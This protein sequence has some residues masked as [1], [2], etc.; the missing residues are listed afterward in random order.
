MEGTGLTQVLDDPATL[1]YLLAS[2]VILLVYIFNKSQS[3]MLKAISKI[4]KNQTE[5][6]NKHNGLSKDFY[7]L[8]G[9]HGVNHT[10][11]AESKVEAADVG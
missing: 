6:F 3:N 1:R 5:L 9:Q 8:K 2:I 7:L 11:R 4:D 10:R